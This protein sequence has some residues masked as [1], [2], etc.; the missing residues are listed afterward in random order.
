MDTM[1]NTFN[2]GIGFVLIV[3][4]AQAE[5]SRSWFEAQGIAA[6]LIGEVIDGAGGVVGLP[7]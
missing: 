3:P 6:Y 2:M 4:P 1:F 7:K 5:Q